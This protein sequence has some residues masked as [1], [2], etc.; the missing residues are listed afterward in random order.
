MLCLLAIEVSST[1]IPKIS[2]I[3]LCPITAK[4]IGSIDAKFI[5][6]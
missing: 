4:G 2:G 3:N 5:I 6:L 1:Q